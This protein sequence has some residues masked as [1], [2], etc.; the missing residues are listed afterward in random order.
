MPWFRV[1]IML[2]NQL[3]TI[4]MVNED[5][6]IVSAH[7]KDNAVEDTN[8]VSKISATTRHTIVVSVHA[9]NAARRI[10]HAMVAY[11]SDIPLSYN[12]AQSRTE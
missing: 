6:I 4:D 12:N 1:R 8:V 10:A 5:T 9:R 7:A 11:N 2:R 3:Q